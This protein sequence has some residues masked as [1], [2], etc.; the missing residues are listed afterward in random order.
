MFI[1]A[2]WVLDQEY[3]VAKWLWHKGGMSRPD[4]ELTQTELL[5]VGMFGLIPAVAQ[6]G[7]IGSLGYSTIASV[8]GRVDDFVRLSRLNE[9]VGFSIT[10]KGKLTARYAKHSA[11]KMGAAKLGARFIPYLGWALLATD[12]YLSSKWIYDKFS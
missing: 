3:K 1:T 6:T 10:P 4:R 11:L 12:V 8:G 9:P 7:A 2:L 5:Y